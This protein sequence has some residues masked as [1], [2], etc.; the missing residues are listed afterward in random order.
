MASFAFYPI[1]AT[2][3]TL[4]SRPVI[5][6]YG[7]TADKKQLCVQIEG[8]EAYFYILPKDKNWDALTAE[9]EKLHVKTRDR[10]VKVARVEQAEKIIHVKKEK[11]LK[12]YTA[13]PAD[14]KHLRDELKEHKHIQ[15]IFDADIPFVR[16]FCIDH[17]IAPLS[18]IDVEAEQID[19]AYKVPVFRTTADKLTP[20]DS[21]IYEDLKVLALD[22]ETYSP[23]GEAILPEKYPILMV[24]FAGSRFK[25]VITW[26]KFK[27]K[28][29]TIEFVDSEQALLQRIVE[30]IEEQQPDIL[31][32]YFSDGFDLPYMKKRAEH[33]GVPLP[34]GLDKG[35]IRMRH[36]AESVCRLTGIV[37]LDIFKFIRKTMFSVLKTSEY[38]LDAVSDELLGERKDKV[39]LGLLADVWDSSPEKLGPYCEYNLQDSILT[40]KLYEKLFDNLLELVKVVGQSIPVVSRMAYSQLVE[41]YLI[42][43]AFNQGRVVPMGPYG[44]TIG[45]RRRQTFQGAFVV[46]P[47][48]GLHKD[49]IVFDFRSLYPSII[50]AHNISPETLHCGCCKKAVVPEDPKTWFCQK[51]KGF[52]SGVIEN[53]ITR[54]IR[55]KEILSK[56][57]KAEKRV[58]YA[59][60]YALKTVANSMYGYL[61]FAVA[62]WYSI[63]AARSITAYGRYYIHDAIK[64]AEAA[65][66]KVLYGDTDSVFL[67]LGE[68]SRE[69]AETFIESVNKKLPGLMELEFEGFYP[70]GIFV[71]IKG[72]D[73]PSG[74]KKK[75][76]LLGEDGEMIIKGFE[77]VKRN[78]AHI[79]KE[80]QE[81]ILDIILREEDVK[82]AFEFMRKTIA[83]VRE[84]KLPIEKVILMTRLQKPLTKYQ[85]IGPHV[86]AGIRLEKTGYPVGPGTLVK[87]IITE[88]EG[89]ISERARLPEEIQQK[90]YDAE[91][92]IFHQI[93]PVVEKIF[94]VLGYT[95]EQ[96]VNEHFQSTLGGYF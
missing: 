73:Q 11:L 65:G 81:T 54:R 10:I 7:R 49:I 19:S 82:K 46:K 93:I 64:R 24:A 43:E 23:H 42:R 29:K 57:T 21:D 59:R 90:D 83:E 39:D 77:S 91:Y 26:N 1:H 55:I 69:E 96:L 16:R 22:I 48:P 79:A 31:V 30:V 80:V 76:A 45:R 44:D 74:A 68:K 3:K 4:S 37:H 18:R 92:Y 70:R 71:S 8:V 14:V 36:T 58:L 86:A 35:D 88:G 2:Y 27:T 95:K 78:Y 33:L 87:Y 61:S 9:L 28:D 50:S 56:T 34:L 66:F 60:Q 15:E 84:H 51:E 13:L 52:I 5:E 20:Q 67:S 12:V 62:R 6:L 47:E 53:L 41:W 94:E 72:G 25:K 89:K 40:Y 75:Y 17:N 85:S 38:S 63:E 32:G